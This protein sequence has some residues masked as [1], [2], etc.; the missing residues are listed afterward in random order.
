MDWYKNQMNPPQ[1]AVLPKPAP[2]KGDS[3]VDK[4]SRAF[5]AVPGVVEA[6]QP[7]APPNPMDLLNNF[8]STQ[9][10]RSSTSKNAAIQP[11]M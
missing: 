5:S 4:I 11:P 6:I 8:S 2:G 3:I 10:S 9:S 7:P 1:P